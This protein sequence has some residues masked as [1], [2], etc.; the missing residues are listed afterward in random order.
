M[1]A[2]SL[3]EG[4]ALLKCPPWKG[5]EPML[6][7]W[8]LGAQQV[9]HGDIKALL[10]GQ[11]TGQP[12]RMA[13][14]GGRKTSVKVQPQVCKPGEGFRHQ[15]HPKG[16]IEVYPGEAGLPLYPLCATQNVNTC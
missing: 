16:A 12:Q 2:P 13:S 5:N 9:T 1:L 4:S 8:D 3:E 14:P 10:V 6:P 11:T 7:H 15:H